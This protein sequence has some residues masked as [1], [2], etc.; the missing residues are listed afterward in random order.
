MEIQI[1][2]VLFSRSTFDHEYPLHPN[3]FALVHERKIPERT[4]NVNAMKALKRQNK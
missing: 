2:N 3:S 4:A 1:C